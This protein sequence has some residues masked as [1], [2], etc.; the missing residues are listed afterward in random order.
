MNQRMF[1]LVMSLWLRVFYR[2]YQGEFSNEF[3]DLNV[4]MNNEGFNVY[5]TTQEGPI[6]IFAT[7]TS[8]GW[9]TTVVGCSK[10]IERCQERMA[11]SVNSVCDKIVEV[12]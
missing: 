6:G 1:E 5:L 9:S 12:L 7:L 2:T 4:I 11:P 3:K 8:C 10:V